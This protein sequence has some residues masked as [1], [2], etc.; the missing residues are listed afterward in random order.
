[1][2][3]YPLSTVIIGLTGGIASGKSIVI[4][5]FK[6]LGAKIIDADRIAHQLLKQDK[7]IKKEIISFF[8][9]EV[10]KKNGE[11]NRKKLGKIVFADTKK[12]KLL[13]KIVHPLII[14]EIKKKL[15]HLITKSRNH[16]IVIDAP[17]LFEAGITNLVDKIIVV[18]VPKKIQLKRLMKRN[19]INKKEAEQRISSQ[20]DIRKKVK[21]AD[22]VI[23]NTNNLSS[24]RKQV[25]IIWNR[26]TEV[27]IFFE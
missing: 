22:F 27:K 20:W 5:E 1:T 24:L 16:C 4:N 10:Q 8:G 13:E 9:E 21:S 2:N 7:K 25:E 11:I 12:R 17:L 18:F 26:I 23:N 14:S 15:N 3:H 19:Q 6:K